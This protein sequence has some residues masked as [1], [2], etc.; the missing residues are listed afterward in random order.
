[1]ALPSR[2]STPS[3]TS[4]PPKGEAP[5][6]HTG[7][8][9]PAPEIRLPTR[10]RSSSKNAEAI[11]E[12]RCVRSS[13]TAFD[14]ASGVDKVSGVARSTTPSTRNGRSVVVMQASSHSLP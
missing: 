5:R 4:E 14:C 6:H 2:T 7:D 9:R 11:N 1:V 13:A 3:A 10:L 12:R 8:C